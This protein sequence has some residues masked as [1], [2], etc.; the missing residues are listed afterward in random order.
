MG[1]GVGVR[2]GK[3]EGREAGLGDQLL[4]VG[5]LRPQRPSGCHERRGLWQNVSAP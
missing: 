1:A 2:I 3:E 5:G 4:P